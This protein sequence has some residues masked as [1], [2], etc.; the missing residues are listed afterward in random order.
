MGLYVSVVLLAELAALSE[1][2]L[3]H[4]LALVALI[5]G[6]CAGLAVAHWF[7]FTV[8]SKA[9]GASGSLTRRDVEMGLIQI[10]AAAVVAFLSTVPLLVLPVSSERRVTIFVPAVLIGLAGWFIG[11]SSGHSAGRSALWAA[12]ILLAGL[13][14]AAIKATLGH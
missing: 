10:A 5:W 2:H 13:L 7:S 4:G 12:G 3:P 1:E 6:T 14:V 11:R 9:L 8:A